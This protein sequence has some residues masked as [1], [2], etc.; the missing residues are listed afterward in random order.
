MTTRWSAEPEPVAVEE[1]DLKLTGSGISLERKVDRDAA[2]QILAIAMGSAAGGGPALGTPARQ[3]Q[4]QAAGSSGGGG[5]ISLR[6]YLDQV[7]A[8]RNPD[9]ILA[10]GQFLVEHRG[11]DSFTGDQIKGQFRSAGEAIPGNFSRDFRW[12]VTNGW[13]AEDHASRGDYYV[14]SSGDSALGSHFSPEIKKKTSQ[15]K[16]TARKRKKKGDSDGEA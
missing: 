13:I 6:E 5:R 14:T 7:E 10:I 9:K 4:R 1:F 15:T 8:K 11:Q 16:L 3:I 2:L 12:T